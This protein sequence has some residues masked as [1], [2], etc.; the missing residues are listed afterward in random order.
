MEY[1]PYE[2]LRNQV[3]NSFRGTLI[4][5]KFDVYFSRNQNM[6]IYVKE[7]CREDDFRAPIFVHVVPLTIDDFPEPNKRYGFESRGFFFN[8]YGV[9][10]GAKCVTARKLPDYPISRIS[11]G[12]YIDGVLLWEG[13]VDLR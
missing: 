5:S 1:L 3:F 13:T 8:E 11:T 9:V 12:A 10:D 6:L 2:K 4:R 7:P